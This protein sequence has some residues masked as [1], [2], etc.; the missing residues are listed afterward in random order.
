MRKPEDQNLRDRVVANTTAPQFLKCG[1]GGGKTR[2][3]VD[4]YVNLLDSGV[5]AQAIVAVTF[6]R[7]A[8]EELR[9]RIRSECRKKAREAASSMGIDEARR[10]KRLAW[11]VES[12]TITTIH[13]L[14]SRILK[15][16]A[17]AAK[18]DP[19]FQ[20]AEEAASALLQDDTIRQTV[21]KRLEAGESSAAITVSELGL[22]GTCET[23][24]NL[25]AQRSSLGAVLDDADGPFSD[26]TRLQEWW[27][28]RILEQAEKRLGELLETQEWHAAVA[29]MRAYSASDPEDKL[30]VSRRLALE[31]VRIIEADDWDEED[32]LQTKIA[33]VRALRSVP[34]RSNS[35]K[36]GDWG[37]AETKSIVNAAVKMLVHKDAE[38]GK[39]LDG[40]AK[41]GPG[42]T[43][44]RS[45]KLTCALVAETRAAIAAYDDVKQSQ[46]LL[47]FDDLQ[48]RVGA[49]WV[50]RP[51]VLA[52]YRRSIKHLL[53][54]EF[55]DTSRMQWDI[56]RPIVED[57][58]PVLI[59]VGDDKQ[60][61]YGFRNADLTLWREVEAYVDALAPEAVT[62][63]TTCFR[64]T[65]G[66]LRFFNAFFISEQVMGQSPVDACD[67]K[68]FAAYYDEQLAAFRESACDP[69]VEIY[70]VGPSANGD[71]SEDANGE[72]VDDESTGT[73]RQKEAALLAKRVYE[74]VEIEGLQIEDKETHE[75][76]KV[77]YGDFAVLLRAFT[78]VSLYEGAF[79]RQGVP[80]YVYA[81]RGF[82][83]LQ[84]V[85]DVVN[86]LRVLENTG[87]EMAL[88]G[89]LRS[90]LFGI[91][92]ETLFWM[93]QLQGETTWW[94]RLQAFAA[95]ESAL[96]ESVDGALR[97]VEE[98]I[99][100]AEFA[101]VEFAAELFAQLRERKNR[102]TP[103]ELISEIV[104]RTGF[105]AT[106]AAQFVGT[107][108]VANVEKLIDTAAAFENSG[109]FS[110][111][112]FVDYLKALQAREEREGQAAVED[113]HS[114]S[115][116]ILTQHASKGLE[117]PVVIVPDLNRQPRNDTDNVRSHRDFGLVAHKK[118]DEG[119]EWPAV[120]IF[121]KEQR[122][123]EELA[124]ARR[125]FYVACTR[126][127]DRL[128]LSGSVKY[129]KKE[130]FDFSDKRP[131][132]WVC[133]GL[134]I[135][136]EALEELYKDDGVMLVG[137][138]EVHVIH[139]DSVPES[140]P[141]SR[142]EQ[143]LVED[144][145][146]ALLTGGALV[147][148]DQA[149]MAQLLRQS[150]A[151]PQTF[152]AMRRF[153]VTDLSKY[154]K[155][156]GEYRIQSLGRVPEALPELPLDPGNIELSGA[157][158]GDVVHHLLRLVGRGG[159]SALEEIIAQ[160]AGLPVH[161]EA[162]ARTQLC[163]IQR[164]VRTFLNT[165]LYQRVVEQ[166]DIL[167]TE[168]RVV[169]AWDGAMIEGIV[170]AL[171]EKDGEFYL[172]DYKTGRPDE[173]KSRMYEFQLG[174]YCLAI[175]AA[176]GKPV[177][178]A[179]LVYLPWQQEKELSYEGQSLEQLR[180][181][182]RAG[183]DVSVNGI[184][185]GLFDDSE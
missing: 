120:G 169:F 71:D 110:L 81:G 32:A 48:S 158:Y 133:G 25:L 109:N 147:D 37:G 78:D 64:S 157:E 83:A 138:A 119:D 149:L 56:F 86:C 108:A 2:L 62:A 103:S 126:A 91:S 45:A 4:H 34:F 161:L 36:A 30:E 16:N 96:V 92:D 131:L 28:A 162:R 136:A 168:M 23:V 80:F 117:W 99:G 75:M 121:I 79:R 167:R 68:A 31:Q 100:R 146:A 151:V 50:Q 143:W 10:W 77:H 63:L 49:L 182:A 60:S 125:L 58:G 59:V 137:D 11:D 144:R 12:A 102:L 97:P 65:P 42:P 179:H 139:A 177:R 154:V 51:D 95:G 123:E 13:G 98:I 84:E 163:T 150:A 87:D 181:N 35:G 127:R 76:R 142:G 173:G 105:T 53:V 112:E 174:A 17:I 152:G 46:S 145:R 69:P 57:G 43:D 41:C 118:W 20:L 164:D 5:A 101:K 22:A 184:R 176:T 172:I 54:D 122:D 66:L 6:T 134:H 183:L 38:L 93:R 156:P 185:S 166:A 107:Q 140:A 104:H 14:C 116:K 72:D 8:A 178:S 111:R 124:E 61:I 44:E 153:T 130:Q 128:I 89:A 33:A 85:R 129:K 39:R 55:Q 29:T 27:Q 1:A 114:E 73:L 135:G 24:G 7:K 94:G 15:E 18:I 115:V 40:I 106:L 113:E 170:D 67:S 3:M 160:D 88:A 9:Q 52:R 148:A 82:Y 155:S 74:L 141:Q 19:S 90:P 171:V 165:A 175:E 70:I 21:L 26:A 159:I 180:T 47:D 132:G